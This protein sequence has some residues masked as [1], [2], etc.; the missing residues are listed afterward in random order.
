MRSQIIEEDRSR[1]DHPIA[2]VIAGIF[3]SLC[4][5]LWI[6]ILVFFLGGFE[7]TWIIAIMASGGLVGYLG[8]L[9][10]SKSRGGVLVPI[11]VAG[12]FGGI[13]GVITLFFVT[14]IL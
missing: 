1:S 6:I 8:G 10:V 7:L 13:A 14:R 5:T 2:W 3:G 9:I 11:L 4:P 12:I